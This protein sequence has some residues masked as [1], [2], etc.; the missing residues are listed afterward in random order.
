MYVDNSEATY[1]LHRVEVSRKLAAAAA[2]PCAR[3]A[4]EE[5]GSCYA[6]RLTALL[7][8]A[9]LSIPAQAF[10]GQRLRTAQWA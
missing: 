2:G 8:V 3:H 9:T 6:A 4:H 1:L 10:S 5:L 7:R